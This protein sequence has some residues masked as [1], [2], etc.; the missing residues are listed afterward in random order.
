MSG[1]KMKEIA[2][3]RVDK[4]KIRVAQPGSGFDE[5]IEDSL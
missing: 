1:R 3:S 2:Q 4:T 5:C